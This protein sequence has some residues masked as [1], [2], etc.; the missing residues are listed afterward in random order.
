[1]GSA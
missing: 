1:V